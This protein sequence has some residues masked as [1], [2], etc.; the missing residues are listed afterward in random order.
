VNFVKRKSGSILQI[1]SFVYGANV[2]KR[3]KELIKKNI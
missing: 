3:E 2:K 1:R